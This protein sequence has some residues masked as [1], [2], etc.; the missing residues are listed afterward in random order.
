MT[1][2]T[3]TVLMQVHALLAGLIAVDPQ[4]AAEAD[5]ELIESTR[6]TEE[7]SGL[8]GILAA[9]R[10]GEIANRSRRELGRAG[11][12][13]THGHVNAPALIR[14]IT[15]SSFNE[16]ALRI[17]VGTVM[18]DAALARQLQSPAAA[19]ENAAPASG[20]E[21]TSGTP[22]SESVTDDGGSFA[23]VAEAIADGS[24]GIDAADKVIRTLTPM[25]ATANPGLLSAATATLVTESVTR[26]AD[27]VGAMARGVRDTLDRAGVA[28]REAVLRSKRSLRRGA[29]VDGLRRVSLVLDPESDVL[30]VGAIDTIMSPRLGGPRFREPAANDAAALL[31]NDPRT[32]EQLALDVLVDLVTA[33]TTA[34]PDRMPAVTGPAVRVIMSVDDLVLTVFEHVGATDSNDPGGAPGEAPRGGADSRDGEDPPEG[35]DPRNGTDARG[36]AT[37]VAILDGHPELVSAATARRYLCNQGV[38][39][40]VLGGD[41]VPLDLGRTRRLFSGAQRIALA[42]RDGGCRWPGCDRPPSWTESHHVHE[43]QHGG[44]TDLKD[45]IALCRR[46]HLL[47]HNNGWSIHRRDESETVYWLRPPTMLD[48]TQTLIAMP[49]K[50]TML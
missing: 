13:A 21:S 11:L 5:G 8:I 16:A 22:A 37:G 17:R 38:L 4:G 10:A 3:T 48:P 34:N 6:L 44:K 25:L 29:V 18:N 41:S 12:A 24:L 36:V 49:S 28:D 42:I 43:Y 50:A 15:R 35:A 40:V 7:V 39:P 14:S 9:R 27:E 47:L 32:N 33:G 19:N 23:V 2:T 30:L 45:G 20:D 46:H 31:V 1:E 26:H